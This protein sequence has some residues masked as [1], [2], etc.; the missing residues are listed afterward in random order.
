M[1]GNFMV[2]VNIDFDIFSRFNKQRWLRISATPMHYEIEN[3]VIFIFIMLRWI[4]FIDDRNIV[5]LNQWIFFSCSCFR[6]LVNKRS[7]LT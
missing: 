6:Y 5:K 1:I 3:Y 4:L 7:M 2:I